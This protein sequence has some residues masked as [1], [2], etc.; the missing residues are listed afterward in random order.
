[1]STSQAQLFSQPKRI[2]LIIQR[3][4][5]PVV[6]ALWIL[7]NDTCHEFD[8]ISQ[9]L[10]QVNDTYPLESED[11]GLEDYVTE[12]GG[13]EVAHFQRV[14]EALRDE[15]RVVIRPLQTTEIRARQ[16]S[17]RY[18]ISSAGQHLIDGIPFGKSNLKRPHRPHIHIP[19]RKRRRITNDEDSVGNYEQVEQIPELLALTNGEDLDESSDD[20]DFNPETESSDDSSELSDNDDNTSN[21]DESNFD[22]GSV[23]SKKSV[24]FED[25]PAIAFVSSTQANG[26]STEVDDSDDLPEEQSSKPKYMAV[27]LQV[28]SRRPNG[29]VPQQELQDEEDD[30]EDDTSSFELS[31]S[32]S[33]VSELSS[34]AKSDSASTDSSPELP[35]E[36]TSESEHDS[37][38]SSESPKSEQISVPPGE[39]KH[40][41]K[42]R[43]K[44]RRDKKK[45]EKLK[46]QG[47]LS[48]SARISDLH[49]H[50]E[51]NAKE[52]N[53]SKENGLV[54][55]QAGK[56]E[57]DGRGAMTTQEQDEL[58]RKRHELIAKLQNESVSFIDEEKPAAVPTTDRVSAEHPRSRL[59]IAS[60]RRHILASL[61]L[62]DPAKPS[63]RNKSKGMEPTP[64][65]T[66]PNDLQVE[67]GSASEQDP[68]AWKSKIDLRAIECVVDGVELSTPPFPFR[69]VWDSQQEVWA[70][71]DQAASARRR[72]NMKK[73]G[74]GS[75]GTLGASSIQ[76]G[77]VKR[78]KFDDDENATSAQNGI[79]NDGVVLDYGEA[80]TLNHG[81]WSGKGNAEDKNAVSTVSSAAKG[82]GDDDNT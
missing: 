38:R 72:K 58:E 6:K 23:Q 53:S 39:G 51:A 12:I 59:D 63:I 13:F 82:I 56:K 11:W 27:S 45:L 21:F 60:S 55:L 1:M 4:A 42:A 37:N 8:T 57:D 20:G 33:E 69:K 41:T 19:P 54:A 43:N 17:G 61:G 79:D 40:V 24:R 36:S 31:D 52:T 81:D 32:S 75:Y 15:D 48:P 16:V 22:T 25:E 71:E 76:D 7:P 34:D 62:R 3:N 47:V 30:S 66:E 70:Q 49:A 64:S 65:L 44:R 50:M 67:P 26:M 28:D 18:Q 74:R 35:P 46:Q 68:D 10:E 2:Q 29:R 5:L 14:T 78:V 9:L 77:A 80:E 73:K